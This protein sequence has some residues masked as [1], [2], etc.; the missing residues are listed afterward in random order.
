M[1]LIEDLS[2]TGGTGKSVVG[3]HDPSALEHNRPA[4]GEAGLADIVGRL[5]DSW[6]VGPGQ[7][8]GGITAQRNRAASERDQRVFAALID[9]CLQFQ[10]SFCTLA[11]SDWSCKRAVLWARRPSCALSN[12]SRRAAVFSLMS[13]VSRI[14]L[15]PFA[16]SRAAEI[17]PAMPPIAVQSIFLSALSGVGCVGASSIA[18]GAAGTFSSLLACFRLHAG[19]VFLGG[20]ARNV[21]FLG[22]RT[23]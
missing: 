16:M 14:A 3:T 20:T 22:V 4:N 1:S 5:I 6:L 8:V 21:L 7:C 11:R 15:I 12:C 23:T 13:A 17:D 2:F 9:G 18:Q 10:I 19:S